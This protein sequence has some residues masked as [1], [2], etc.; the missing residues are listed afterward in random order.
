MKN[1]T[2]LNDLSV[3]YATKKGITKKEAEQR[4]KDLLAIIEEELL[5]P[6]KDGIQIVDFLTLRKVD[7]KQKLARNPKKPTEDIIIPAYTSY[8][9]IL[10]KKFEDKLNN[11]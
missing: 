1:Y 10:S 4:V 9:C 2:G 6:D 7:R 5:R 8:K 3:A 11:E